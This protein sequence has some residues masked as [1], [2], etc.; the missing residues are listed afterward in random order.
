VKLNA[1]GDTL[2]SRSITGTLYGSDEEANKIFVSS[3]AVI[4][5][6]YVKNSGTGSEVLVAKYDFNGNLLWSTQYNSAFNE[7]ERSA[8]MVVDAT[9]NIYITGRT[10]IDPV[11]TS[12]NEI[13]IQKY[14]TAGAV[15]WT[16][17]V[18]GNV[19]DDRGKFIRLNGTNILV[20]AR[21]HN[22]TNQDIWLRMLNANGQTVW[23]TSYDSGFD[24][25]V[26]DVEIDASNNI[27]VTGFFNANGDL[28]NQDVVTVKYDSA[29]AL[30][31]SNTYAGNAG[32]SDE[33][34]ALSVDSAGNVY[35]CGISDSDASASV[36][37][38]WFVIQVLSNGSTGWTSLNNGNANQD[39]IADDISL[40][41]D[42]SPFVALH[43]DVDSGTDIN[44]DWKV[45]HLS[46]SGNL[47]SS[48]SYSQSDS[49]DAPNLMKWANGNLFVGGS[50]WNTTEQRNK[51]LVKYSFIPE[52][53]E[54][55]SLERWQMFPNPAADVLFVNAMEIG[56]DLQYF[57]VYDLGGREVQTGTLRFPSTQIDISNLQSGSY[58]IQLNTAKGSFTKT[59]IKQ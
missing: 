9:G 13:L 58:L 55:S 50:T 8:D 31:W 39:D 2:W 11:S 28:L 43:S 18:A 35:V 44:Y 45:Q 42:S 22:G 21:K 29:G 15:L 47:M 37:L 33:P 46:V 48:I 6:G 1:A 10:D 7:S 16:N 49:T 24:D 4:I 26:T 51:L 38:D 12:N 17:V 34:T 27:Y 53:V 32:D 40:G 41:P 59:F 14:S 23:T 25:D 5:S 30:V 3:N 52:S 57:A 20:V 54:E 36:N 19:E 56:A